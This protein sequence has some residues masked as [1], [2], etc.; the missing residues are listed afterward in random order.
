MKYADKSIVDDLVQRGRHRQLIGGMWEELGKLQTDFLIAQGLKP[1]HRLIDVGAGSLRA[2]VPL[3]AYLD[4]H[5]YYGI[6]LHDD[7]LQAGLEREIEPAGLGA[8]L[9]ARN[10][11]ATGVFDVSPFGVRFDYGIAQSV[12]THMALSHLTDCLNAL[13]PYFVDGGRYYVTYFECPEDAP[14]DVPYTHETGGIVTHGDQDPFHITQS[15]LHDLTPEGWRLE[16]IGNWNHPR[17]QRM[18]LFHRNGE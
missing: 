14:I 6:D 17:D 1:H 3:T 5:N 16:I 2:G 15:G 18:A 11:H 9:T 10:L 8:K 12:F 13:A 4:P 7:L